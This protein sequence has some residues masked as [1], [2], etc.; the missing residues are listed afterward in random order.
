ME[1]YRCDKCGKEFNS[2]NA[3]SQH[4]QDYDHSKLENGGGKLKDRLPSTDFNFQQWRRA[5]GRL[6]RISG[7]IAIVTGVSVFLLLTNWG[8]SVPKAEIVSRD[9]IHRHVELDIE[10]LGDRRQI[11][12]NVGIGTVEKPIHT[13]T[14]P[15]VLHLEFSGL[16]KKEDIRLG[17]FFEIWG[18]RFSKECILNKCNGTE[19]QLKMFVNGKPNYKFGDYVM[20]DKDRIKIVFN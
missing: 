5:H 6:I 8:T 19:G 10:I 9:G 13:H 14:E 4:K 11:P 18:K 7:F 17:R 16:V 3:L 1:K 15:N 2:E 20:Q 12:I